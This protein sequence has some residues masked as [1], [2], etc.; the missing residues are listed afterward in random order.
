MNRWQWMCEFKPKFWGSNGGRP[1]R[2]GRPRKSSPE[3]KECLIGLE[4]GNVRMSQKMNAVGL[5]GV[6]VGKMTLGNLC[7]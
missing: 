4:G 1:E 6:V 3:I 7:K 5:W 2:I